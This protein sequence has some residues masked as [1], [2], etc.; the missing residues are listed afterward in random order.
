M[1]TTTF[2]A[3]F[4]EVARHGQGFLPNHLVDTEEDAVLRR[5]WTGTLKELLET[6]GELSACTA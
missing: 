1:L 3:S 4:F 6:A 2:P 5:G